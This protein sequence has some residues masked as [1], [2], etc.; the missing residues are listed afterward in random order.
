MPY[1]N[2]FQFMSE[3]R[4]LCS[5]EWYIVNVVAYGLLPMGCGLWAM[6]DGQWTNR[7]WAMSNGP[8]AK[9]F[10]Y[11][12]WAISMAWQWAVG[13]GQFAMGNGQ[14]AIVRWAMGNGLWTMGNGQW[15]MGYEL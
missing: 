5:I 11:G 7:Q 14:L 4:G 13:N 2:R 15:A 12:L 3:V 6:S 9:G 10:G 1:L 8:W